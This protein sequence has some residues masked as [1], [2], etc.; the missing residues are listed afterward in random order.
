MSSL[1][2]PCRA[3]GD[4]IAPHCHEGSE[5]KED[6]NGI[7]L[8]PRVVDNCTWWRCATCGAYGDEAKMRYVKPLGR[9]PQKDDQG[10]VRVVMHYETVDYGD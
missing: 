1:A 10:K 6:E 9:H 5:L 7:L 4:P 3:C 2:S 8:G